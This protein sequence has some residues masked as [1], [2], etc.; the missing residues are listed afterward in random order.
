MIWYQQLFIY[1]TYFVYFLYII[2]A[3]GLANSEIPEYL[4]YLNYFRQIYI[5]ITLLFVFNPLRKKPKFTEFHRKIIFISSLFLLLPP[6]FSLI[7]ELKM[8]LGN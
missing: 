6:V 8:V 5:G 2:T 1:I 4:H 7:K 3:I